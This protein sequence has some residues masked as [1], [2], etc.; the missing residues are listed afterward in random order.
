MIVEAADVFVAIVHQIEYLQ[1]GRVNC[2]MPPP[3]PP[4]L[5]FGVISLPTMFLVDKK[6]L[7]HSRPAS[8][9]DVKA[10]LPEALDLKKPTA[11][12]GAKD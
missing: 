5:A 2:I 6:G 10:A 3:I 8:I 9:E 12:A 11:T 7:V 1:P 4:S